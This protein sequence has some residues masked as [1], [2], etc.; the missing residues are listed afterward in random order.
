MFSNDTHSHL[1]CECNKER[2]SIDQLYIELGL[3]QGFLNGKIFAYFCLT[4]GLSE[5][6][7]SSKERMTE[8]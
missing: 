3:W 8:A 2:G 7:C 6:A 1:Y 4:F 5:K